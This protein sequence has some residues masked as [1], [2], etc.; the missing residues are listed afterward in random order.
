M[1]YVDE[2]RDKERIKLLADNIRA[3]LD[4]DREYRFM[5]VCGTHT[6]AIARFGLK[7]I[8]PENIKLLSGPGC[9]VCVTPTS[10][11]DKAAS[12][13][14]MADTIIATFG[15]MMKVPGSR[16]SLEKVRSER[17]NVKSVYSTIDAL[18]LASENPDKRIIFL[19]VGFE[20]TAP[21]IAAAIK[22]AKTRK[23]DNFFVLCGHKIMPPALEALLKDKDVMLDGFILPAHVSAIIGSRPYGFIS[24]EYNM[25][26]AITGFEPLDIM[27]GIYM[28]IK[29]L[30]DKDPKIDIQ[31]NR[32]VKPSGNKLAQAILKEVF[33]T[34]DSEWRG[35]G[36]IPGSGL[37]IRKKFSSIDAEKNF[38]IPPIKST[39]KDK[40]CICGEVLK[41][42]KTP[43]DC[44]LFGK[45]CT[46]ERPVGPCMVSS[47]G[48]CSAEYL[49]K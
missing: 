40:G 36:T 13:A 43:G 5:E 9:P 29:Q 30:T 42:I 47:E 37:A 8:L 23:I 34:V 16:T 26:C 21:T 24:K 3:T 20:T 7:H 14:E 35:L 12:Y 25:A 48:S 49:Y 6:M 31:Y 22:G 2:F 15:D 46:P 18:K 11:I 28:L 27:Q 19:G 1:K 4:P 44:R 10:Y 39:G 33:E 32:V 17:G 45:A 41:G 38:K